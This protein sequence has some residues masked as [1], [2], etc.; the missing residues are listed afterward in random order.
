MQYSMVVRVLHRRADRQEKAQAIL[1]RQ[2]VRVAVRDDVGA[3][4]AFEN[5]VRP[6]LA[7]AAIQHVSDIWMVERCQNL[8][9]LQETIA[10][11]SSNSS[12][13]QNLDGNFAS[14]GTVIAYGPVDRAHAAVPQNAGDAPGAESLRMQSFQKGRSCGTDDL[15]KIV[16][17]SCLKQFSHFIAK[18]G[19]WQC[20]ETA[21]PFFGR[22]TNQLKVNRL[23]FAEAFRLHGISLVGERRNRE[24]YPKSIACSPTQGC[25]WASRF[26]CESE[27]N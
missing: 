13:G 14:V 20:R 21:F 10:H 18:R 11:I 3:I 4:D 26:G 17:R 22:K 2:L 25:R 15:R 9:L 24:K 5:D 16:R 27:Y 6:G 8:A 7:L 23:E 19:V 12:C 1:Y